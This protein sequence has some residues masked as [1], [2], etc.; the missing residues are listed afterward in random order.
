M[1][2]F[3]V[4]AGD[5]AVAS[6]FAAA[7]EFTEEFFGIELVVA[8]GIAEAVEA[9]AT[10]LFVFHEIEGVEDVAEAVGAGDL[11]IEFLDFNLRFGGGGPGSL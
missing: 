8:V 2:G 5:D 11:C 9:V 6:V 7:F 4:R 3:S 10:A 1:E